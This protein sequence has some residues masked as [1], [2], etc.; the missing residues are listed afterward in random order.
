MGHPKT[1][2]S[3][4][5]NTQIKQ[6]GAVFLQLQ[7]TIS[8]QNML[9]HV[10]V[11]SICELMSNQLPIYEYF[12]LLSDNVVHTEVHSSDAVIQTL[13]LSTYSIGH[14]WEWTWPHGDR[15]CKRS[16]NG[17]HKLKSCPLNLMGRPK[18]S[19]S[20]WWNTQKQIG[21][22]FLQLQNIE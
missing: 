4:W 5:W 1:S 8:Y 9:Y 7:T 19:I 18:I 16:K 20:S 2:I 15:L 13:Q 22:N 12:I 21:A 17:Q 3:R 10:H 11:N 14:W 6:T